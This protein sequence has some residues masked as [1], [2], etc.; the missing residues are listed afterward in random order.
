MPKHNKYN[1]GDVVGHKDAP[2][3]QFRVIN[4]LI[5]VPEKAGSY[6]YAYSQI[7]DDD[8]ND[9]SDIFFQLDGEIYTEEDLFFIRKPTADELKK[10]L[11]GSLKQIQRFESI[12]KDIQNEI[13]KLRK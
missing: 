9:F 7:F 6:G 5:G 11:E 1:I 3:L 2:T 12:T 4:V 8:E 13:D 10:L